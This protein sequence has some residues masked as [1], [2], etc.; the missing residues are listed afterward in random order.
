MKKRQYEKPSTKVVELQYQG[1][2]LQTSGQ[3]IIPDN[4]PEQPDPFVF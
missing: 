4:Y 1:H 2:L 3:L